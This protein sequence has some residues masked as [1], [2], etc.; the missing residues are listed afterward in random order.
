MLKRRPHVAAVDDADAGKILGGL[1]RG[2]WPDAVGQQPALGWGKMHLRGGDDGEAITGDD[3]NAESLGGMEKML[4]G[5]TDDDTIR[6]ALDL[7]RWMLEF[8]LRLPSSLPPCLLP[9]PLPLSLSLIFWFSIKRLWFKPQ[10]LVC[11]ILIH[12]HQ[13]CSKNHKVRRRGGG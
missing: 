6:M 13:S 10:S 4:E 2:E 11:S 7:I 8:Q 9:R 3:A 1:R 12:C 5:K